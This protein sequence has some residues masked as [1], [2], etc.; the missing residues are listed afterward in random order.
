MELTGGYTIVTV[1]NILYVMLLPIKQKEK[2]N[3]FTI[4][5]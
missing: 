3:N 4:L 1:V 5:N 2:G